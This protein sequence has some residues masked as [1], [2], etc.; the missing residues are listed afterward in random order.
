[1]SKYYYFSPKLAAIECLHLFPSGPSLAV[2]VYFFWISLCVHGMCDPLR[3]EIVI[4]VCALC[5]VLHEKNAFM[6]AFAEAVAVSRKLSI[7]EKNTDCGR[8]DV[9]VKNHMRSFLI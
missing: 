4:F 6:D 3:H 7:M 5:I 2:M 9:N 8:H 1:M